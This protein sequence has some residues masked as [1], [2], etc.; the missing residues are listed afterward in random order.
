MRDA[1]ALIL[2]DACV[3]RMTDS[4]GT[5][6]VVKPIEGGHEDDAITLI[7]VVEDCILT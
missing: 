1:G 4:R 5:I 6:I 7:V 2:M 3:G